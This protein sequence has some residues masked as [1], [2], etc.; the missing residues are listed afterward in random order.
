MNQSVRLRIVSAVVAVFLVAR[1]SR[2]AEIVFDPTNFGV[3]VEQVAHHLE[4][5]RRFDRQIRNQLRMLENWRFTRLSELMAAMEQVRGTIDEAANIDLD[6]QYSIDEGDYANQDA[7]EMASIRRERLESHRSAVN[8]AKTAKEQV[9]AEMPGHQLRLQQYLERSRNAPGQTA[10]L[11]ASNE[12]L[13]ALAAQLHNL[14][15]LEV[16]ETRVELEEEA[17]RQAEAAF[18]RQRREALMRDWNTNGAVSS[19]QSPVRSP[20]QN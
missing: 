14:Q 16:A 3:N 6:G 19:A 11:Q 8:Q 17:R 20:F 7:S 18:H 15:A 1:P 10:V 13:G 5:I 2:A 12:T 4:L 9:L